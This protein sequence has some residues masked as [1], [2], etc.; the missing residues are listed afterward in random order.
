[1]GLGRDADYPRGYRVANDISHPFTMSAHRTIWYEL[2][3]R[4]WPF[5]T[6]PAEAIIWQMGTG[7]KPNLSQIGM[8]K[9]ISDILLFCWAFEQEER[10]T[11]TKLM[12]MLEKLPKRNRRLSHPGHFWKSAE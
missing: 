8:G 6:Q 10:P 3:A 12:D 4:E 1:P 7:M 2:H 9:E 11:F 5:K